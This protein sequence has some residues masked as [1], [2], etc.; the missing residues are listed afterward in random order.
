MLSTEV[1]MFLVMLGSVA[2][3]LVLT[4]TGALLNHYARR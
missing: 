2:Y 4:G 3:F 1:L